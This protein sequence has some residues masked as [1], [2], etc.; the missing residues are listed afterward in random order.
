MDYLQT[1]R[2]VLDTEIEGLRRVRDQLGADFV[3]LVELCREALRRQG[4]IVLCGVG[5]SGH[6][7]RK[8]AATLASTGSPAAFMLPFE[9][10]LGDLGMLSGRDLMICLSYSGETEEV[11]AVL[12]AAKR[13][14][15]PVVA[16][17]GKPDSALAELSDL[18]V[19][20]AVPAEACP[21]NLAPTTS[22]T[23]ML[24]LGDALAM[25]LMA[26]NEFSRED[27][28]LRHPG[29]SIGRTITLRISD[30]M[31][32]GDRVPVVP[33]NVTVKDA[34]LKMT[35]CHSGSVLVTDGAGLLV[36][37]FTDGDFRRHAQQNLDVLQLPLD[38][39]MTR[40][41]IRLRADELAIAVLQLLET[42]E[43]DDIPVVDEHDRVVGLV[44]IQDL[45]KFKLL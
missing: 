32:R 29:G 21:F 45:P 39:V 2:G 40:K 22:T 42:R 14:G 12:P 41:P 28:G 27:Y 6:I 4:K 33:A 35:T 34:L 37:I 13:F 24:A 36:G 20:V 9:A 38:S 18:V 19:S 8:L 15:V 30:I 23:A 1:A 44:D 25:T 5:K 16:L 3:R 17:T 43:I 11:L 31:R 10:M 26:A 7:A